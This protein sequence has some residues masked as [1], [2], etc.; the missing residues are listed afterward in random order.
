MQPRA[1]GFAETGLGHAFRTGRKDPKICTISPPQLRQRHGPRWRGHGDGHPLAPPLSPVAPWGRRRRRPRAGRRRSH[2]PHGW[3]GSA[4]GRRRCCSGGG[5]SPWGLLR[6]LRWGHRRER[7]GWAGGL[8]GRWPQGWRRGRRC[9]ARTHAWRPVERRRRRG[10]RLHGGGRLR[11]R[12][13]QRG[14]PGG[15]GNTWR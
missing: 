10:G 14:W 4:E 6:H 11:W 2:G 12:P 15:V 3:H 9:W 1:I 5:G 7:R 8:H 13:I